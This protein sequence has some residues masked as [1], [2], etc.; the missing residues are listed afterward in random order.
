MRQQWLRLWLG[1]ALCTVLGCV[2]YGCGDGDTPPPPPVDGG[3][4][5]GTLADGGGRTDM[6]MPPA[7]CGNGDLETGELC[8]DGNTVDGDGCRGDCLSDYACG[9]GVVD[10]VGSGATSDEVCDDGNSVNGD[11]C[12]AAC[13]SDESCGNGIVDLGA[14]EVCD[15][16]NTD[17]GDA[18]NATCTMSLLCGNG[19]M[20]SGEECDDSNVIGGD[21]CSA[22]CLSERCGN[23]RVDASEACDDG[24]ADDTDGCQ[25]DCTFTCSAAADCSD[26]DACNG[27]EVCNDGGSTASRCAAGTAPADGA[28]CGTGLICNGGA[29]VAIACGDGLVSGAEVCDDGNITNADG[30]D[31]DCTLS[32]VTPADCN[33]MNGCTTDAC[34]ANVCSNTGTTGGACTTSGGAA[35]TCNIGMCAASATC[36]NGTVQGTEQCDD[37]NAVNTDGCRTDCTFTCTTANAATNCNDSN[38]CTVD[39]CMGT[40]TASRC[41]RTNATNGTVCDADMMGGTRDICRAGACARTRC[42]DGFR[43]PGA[44]PTEACDDGNTSNGDGCDNDCTFTCASA[45]DCTDPNA[46]NGAETCTMPGTMGSRCAAGAAPAVGSVCD[47]DMMPGTRDI[48]R[49]GGMCRRS[50]CGDGFVDPGAA[51]VESCDDSN[52]VSGDGCSSVCATE[53]AMPPTVFR[54]VDLDLVSPR[55][56]LDVP[57]GGCQDITVNCARAGFLGCQS[58]GINTLLQNA[59]TM[60]EDMPADG[61]FDLSVV[62]AFRPLA[63][64]TA[65]TPVDFYIGADCSTATPSSCAPGTASVVNS[66]ATNMAGGATCF[67]PVAADVNTRAGAPAAYAPAANTVTGPCFI[68]DQETIMITLSG[69]VIPLERARISATY[70]GSPPTQLVS[71][72]ITGFLSE[73]AAADTLLPATLPL[74]GGDPLYSVLQAGG[75]S[76]MNSAGMTIA[77]ACNINEAGSG[78]VAEDDADNVTG[79]ATRGFWFYLN[80]RA[81]L[82]TWTGP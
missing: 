67:T 39:A 72:V 40:G 56:V 77:S 62:S 53:M 74:V 32:C 75:R 30:C 79:P 44:T 49:A 45:A 46:C 7:Q 47:A 48:C 69:I 15:D 66:G 17:D 13:A 51:P 70:S 61:L 54:M 73:R 68:S 25:A 59:V 10:T 27:D 41:M 29:C 16:G 64:A 21:G 35:G 26:G 58:D 11:G 6:S 19:T 55:I 24:N 18:C 9:N 5:G 23:G 2:T 12:D 14:G 52:S 76:V 22:A 57:L 43:D 28:M 82:A 1:T 65:T 42:G 81:T 4:E 36:G 50:T 37:G 71:G 60:D 31:N 3:R 80:F 8:D 20:D 34:T 78:N 38:A 63:P 33:D